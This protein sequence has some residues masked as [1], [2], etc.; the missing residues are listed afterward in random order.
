MHAAV[1]QPVAILGCGLVGASLAAD[2]S[3]AGVEVWGSDRHDLGRLVERG[4]LARQVTIEELAG[5]AAVVVLALPVPAIVGALRRLPFSPGQ[6]VTDTGGVKRSVLAA[7]DRLP[8]SVGFVGGHPMAG[9]T[10]SGPSDAAPGRFRGAAWAL[11]PRPSA[12]RPTPGADAAAEAAA[13]ALAHLAGAEAIRCAAA[14]HD[15]IVALTSHLPQL[16]ATA[17]AAELAGEPGELAARLVGPGGRGLL[18]LAASPH[19]PWQGI[20][21][22]NRDEIL[23]ALAAVTGRAEQPPAALAEDFAAAARYWRRLE[24]GD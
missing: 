23:R 10:G 24:I 13:A 5:A 3:A 15:R 21:E 17:L 6:L 22:G 12:G 7:A 19:G 8:P 16:L 20:L 9:G 4:W 18:R 14:D 11:V 1:P 2:W